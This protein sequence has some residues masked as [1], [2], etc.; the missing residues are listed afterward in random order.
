MR[1]DYTK[2][3][4]K[5][6][7]DLQE[8]IR[9]RDALTIEIA[10]L[11]ALAKSLRAA[12][13]SSREAFIAVQAQ[14]EEVGIQEL[15]LTCIRMSQ[16]PITALEVR[17][18]LLAINFDLTRYANAMAVIHSGIKRLKEAGK[19]KEIGDGFVAAS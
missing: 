5:A 3:Y 8:K 13:L 6:I 2:A 10:R 11:Q 12:A 14:A 4:K 7:A 15:V 9:Q 17:D 1:S 19:I 18:Q 16:R